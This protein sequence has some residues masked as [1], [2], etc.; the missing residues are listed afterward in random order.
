[1]SDMRKLMEMVEQSGSDYQSIPP[2]AV[3][4]EYKA[5]VYGVEWGSEAQ[6]GG[7]GYDHDELPEAFKEWVEGGRKGL[8]E[9]TVIENVG[10]PQN[11]GGPYTA[12]EL[13]LGAESGTTKPQMA[14]ELSE[15]TAIDY[16]IAVLMIDA[17]DA[18]EDIRE[19]FIR[20][21][22]D[23]TDIQYPDYEDHGGDIKEAFL[24]GYQKGH[25]EGYNSYD[26]KS[27]EKDETPEEAYEYWNKYDRESK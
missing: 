3:D 8:Y 14:K 4:L 20:V 17:I 23:T 13:Y 6:Y 10:S 5:F 15:R 2:T 11:V 18:Y 27:W 24:A 19:S 22:E 16:D 9:E 25:I 1:M 12:A 21:Q 26:R 7:G